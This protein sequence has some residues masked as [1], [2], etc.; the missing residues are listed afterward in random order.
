[1]NK[2]VI[3][4]AAASIAALTGGCQTTAVQPAVEESFPVGHWAGKNRFR[5]RIEMR[6]DGVA[7]DRGVT[8]TACWRETS[9]VIA[10]QRLDG[11]ARVSQTGLSVRF[12]IGKGQFH[13]HD[14]GNRKAAMWETRT[15]ADG[16]LTRGLRTR[17]TRTRAPECAQRFA[18]QARIAPAPSFDPDQPIIGHWTGRRADGSIAEVRITTASDRGDIEGTHCTRSASGEIRIHDLA[19]RGASRARFDAEAGTVAFEERLRKGWTR[20]YTFATSGPDG[21]RLD[22]A[23]HKRASTREPMSLAMRRGADPQGC[24]ARIATR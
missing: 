22:S 3:T 11:I 9:G 6:I 17:L 2:M 1:M 23:A 19:R 15:R 24:L 18:V 8:G 5:P 21:A 10:G 7:A 4:L 12:D 20:R 16:T 13:V 14:A